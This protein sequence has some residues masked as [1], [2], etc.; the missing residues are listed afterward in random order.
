MSNETNIKEH[1]KWWHISRR[2]KRNPFDPILPIPQLEYCKVCQMDVDVQVEVGNAD[3]VD[4][5]RKVC[6]RCGNVM[7][8]GIGRRHIDGSNLKPLPPKAMRFIQ[9]KGTD[10]R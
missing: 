8:Y 7:M 1:R 9:Q 6:K 2:L 10:R 5:Y 3:G 4:V